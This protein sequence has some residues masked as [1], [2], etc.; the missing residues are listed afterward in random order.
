LTWIFDRRKHRKDFR[1][2]LNHILLEIVLEIVWAKFDVS[3]SKVLG[4]DGAKRVISDDFNKVWGL[5]RML[6]ES[7]DEAVE[8]KQTPR[9]TIEVPTNCSTQ[10]L[11]EDQDSPDRTIEFPTEHLMEDLPNRPWEEKSRKEHMRRIFGT[12]E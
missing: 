2:H 6:A 7:I 5:T 4:N 1:L 3:L 12:S 11:M 8:D 9:R 10:R